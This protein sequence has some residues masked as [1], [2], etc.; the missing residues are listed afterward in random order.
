MFRFV[1]SSSLKPHAGSRS[2]RFRNVAIFKQN[3][4][5]MSHRVKSPTAVKLLLTLAA[6]ILC[7]L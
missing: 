4:G 5:C 1:H 6:L 2:K 3:A 7:C